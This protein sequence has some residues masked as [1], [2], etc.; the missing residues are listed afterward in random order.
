MHI[1]RA[2]EVAPLTSPHGEI[3]FELIGAAAGGLQSHSVAQVL[4]PPGKASRRHYHP[5]AEESY[6][7]LA[8]Q[9]RLE[10]GEEVVQLGP[11]DA[12]A[13]P[14][15]TAHQIDNAGETDLIFLAVC[16]PAWVPD[17]SVYLD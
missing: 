3:V 1:R 7:I 17:N 12:V 9:A 10:L 11:G 2:H 6:Y 15:G 8:G 4:L 14:A 16:V 13:I 5:V